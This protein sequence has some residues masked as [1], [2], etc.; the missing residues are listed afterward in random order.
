MPGQTYRDKA[1]GFVGRLVEFWKNGEEPLMVTLE[2]PDGA[3]QS[4]LAQ[5][6]ERIEQA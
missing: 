6:V 4:A 1:T 5:N 2:T 3:R